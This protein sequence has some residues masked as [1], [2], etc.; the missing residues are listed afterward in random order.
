M[1]IRREWHG[2]HA[3]AIARAGAQA[4]FNFQQRRAALFTLRL[5]NLLCPEFR[6]QNEF[7]GLNCL[8]PDSKIDSGTHRSLSS[9]TVIIVSM[10][11]H[12]R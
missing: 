11:H 2:M 10:Y 8:K 9:P 4:S 7:G 1:A 3:L 5:Q 12:C 6:L